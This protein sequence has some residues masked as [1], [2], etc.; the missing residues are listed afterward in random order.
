[1]LPISAEVGASECVP[2]DRRDHRHGS[3]AVPIRP[4]QKSPSLT[5]TESWLSTVVFSVLLTVSR[6][7]CFMNNPKACCWHD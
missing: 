4:V 3:V 5:V 6:T 1:M 7:M 2:C